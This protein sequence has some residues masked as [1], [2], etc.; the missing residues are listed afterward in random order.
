VTSDPSM[1]LV[2]D[3]VGCPRVTVRLG[4]DGTGVRARGVGGPHRAGG[5]G[6]AAADVLA[7]LAR[8]GVATDPT[9]ARPAP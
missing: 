2:A 9:R 1:A 7:A 5:T 3:A 8:L 6:P 4:S